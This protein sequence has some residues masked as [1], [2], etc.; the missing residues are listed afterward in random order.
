[1]SYF[2]LCVDLTDKTV[3]LIGSGPQIQEKEERLLPFRPRL[4]RKDDFTPDDALTE[5][6]LVV[7]G[8]T[9][10]PRAEIMANLCQQRRIPVNVVDVPS[11]CTFVFPALIHMGDLTVSIS[12]G[13]RCPGAAAHL[14]QQIRSVLPDR[15]E[16]ILLWLGDVRASLRARYPMRLYRGALAQI[17]RAAFDCGR[18][19]SDADLAAFISPLETS[20]S[21]R[22]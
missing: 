14:K 16:E 10:L 4:I 20:Y 18:P 8:D 13:G 17:T 12:T 11:L 5:P 21:P 6:A 2:P 7:I 1:M 19:L 15:T 22:I 3:Y 9:P